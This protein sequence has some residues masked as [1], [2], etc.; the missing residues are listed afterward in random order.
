[1][2]VSRYHNDCRLWMDSKTILSYMIS[3]LVASRT[4]HVRGGP[5]H[6]RKFA[7]SYSKAHWARSYESILFK[8][9]GSKSM[10]ILRKNYI[11]GV[12]P[13]TVSCVVPLGSI[14]VSPPLGSH[15]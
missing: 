6:L 11:S 5:H 12:P 9:M 1:M 2:M 15:P 10:T 3:S 13:L 7:A 14:V 8:R 4:D